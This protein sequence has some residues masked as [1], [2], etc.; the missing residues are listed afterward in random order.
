MMR[1]C[2]LAVAAWMLLAAWPPDAR[3]RSDEAAPWLARVIW[4]S[5]G[6]SIWVRPEGGSL[7]VRV[8]LEG[9][10]APELCQVFGSRARQAMQTKVSDERVRVSVR[11]HDVYGRAVA[12]VVRVRD[13]ADVARAM[14]REGWAW[15]DRFRNQPVQYGREEASARAARRGLFARSRP[16]RPADFRRRH[17]PCQ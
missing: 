5:D 2:W 8:R 12:R 6:D 16:E 13:G 7:R 15:A 1:C 11:T 3:A 9:I 17:G 4:V 10:D 14:V